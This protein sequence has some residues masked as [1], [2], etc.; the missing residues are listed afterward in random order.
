MTDGAPGPVPHGC[1]ECFYRA[2]IVWLTTLLRKLGASWDD[3][4][5]IS[6]DCLLKAMRKWD[7]LTDPP[8]WIRTTVLR[9]HRRVQARGNDELPRMRRG[10]WE[11]RPHFDKLDLREE[12]ASVL[13]M[14]RRLP[15]AR[16]IVT[17]RLAMVSISVSARHWRAF[18][19]AAYFRNWRD[20]M[21]QL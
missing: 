18:S 16:P 21:A 3:S 17:S 20:D 15:G 8:K 4:W 6:Q 5:D 14:I 12:E 9:E 10:G 13:A 1:F 19:S 11:P 2:D 7:K